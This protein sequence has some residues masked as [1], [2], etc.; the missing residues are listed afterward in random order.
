M[1]IAEEIA[2]FI[3]GYAECAIWASTDDETPLDQNY[4]ARD[5]AS[6]TAQAMANDCLQF[7]AENE[8]ALERF[9]ADLGLNPE[10]ADMERA[11]HDF[12]LTRNYHGAGFWDRGTGAVGD[13]LSRKAQMFNEA[14]LYVGDDGKLYL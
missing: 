11:G 10:F 4:S 6:D 13:E 7:M 3:S 5:L 2:E 1:Y 12:W 14:E 9:C 8:S